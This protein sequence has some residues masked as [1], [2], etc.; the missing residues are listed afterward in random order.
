MPACVDPQSLSLSSSTSSN[1]RK[2]EDDLDND[3]QV[4]RVKEQ[5]DELD[6][7]LDYLDELPDE[8]D[9]L[10]PEPLSPAQAPELVQASIPAQASKQI[11]NFQNLER[12]MSQSSS[13]GMLFTEVSSNNFAVLLIA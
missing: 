8:L 13:F 12:F 4:K 7:A 5:Q 1:K 11:L 2:A 9:E 6:T 10:A 3:D